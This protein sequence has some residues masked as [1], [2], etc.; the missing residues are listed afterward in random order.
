M[1]TVKIPIMSCPECGST[2]NVQQWRALKFSDE[3]PKLASL[4]LRLCSCCGLR[5]ATNPEGLDQLDCDMDADE[6]AMIWPM[7]ELPSL[8][9]AREA[10]QLSKL[11]AAAE[12]RRLI[13]GALAAL[14]AAA[15]LAALL[16]TI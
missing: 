6:Y 16:V 14:L 1:P 12:R 15:L 4:E 2:F 11:A 3:Q 13:A 9:R 7:S 8:A 10:S 5:L